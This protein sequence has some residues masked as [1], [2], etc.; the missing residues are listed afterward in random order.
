[1][2]DEN[3]NELLEQILQAIQTGG[4]TDAAIQA[5]AKGL[6]GHAF[7]SS[8]TGTQ[9]V[10]ITITQ[11]TK[12]SLNFDTVI[13]ED[14]LPDGATTFFTG[15]RFTP[16][17]VGDTY[18]IGVRFYAAS[19]IGNGGFSVSVDISAAGDGSNI[20]GQKAVRMLRGSNSTDYYT[21]GVD[22]FSRDAFIANGGL[23]SI[24]AI[25]G[26]I[27]IYDATLFIV[28]TTAG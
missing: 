4:S 13:Y 7:Y 24:E 26:N 21:V 25:D 27:S 16:Q 9:A 2:A 8:S 28:K 22:V 10:P 12:Q 3:R 17:S 18:Q 19:S 11:G 23:I 1:M 20:V 5:V 14:Y 6:T 15:G